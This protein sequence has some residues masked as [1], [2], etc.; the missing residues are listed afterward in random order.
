MVSLLPRVPEIC[1]LSALLRA[2]V[3][4]L[5]TVRTASRRLRELSAVVLSA[6]V[7]TVK[8]AGARRSSRHSRAGRKAGR[9]GAGRDPG[10]REWGMGVLPGG[11]FAPARVG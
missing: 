3:L 7:L 2:L 1:A 8:R 11:A 10:R 5:F 6:R 9:R 4:P